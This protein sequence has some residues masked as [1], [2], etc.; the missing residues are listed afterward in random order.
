MYRKT[1]NA[2]TRG[3]E[4]KNEICGNLLGWIIIEIYK[5][6]IVGRYVHINEYPYTSTFLYYGWCQYKGIFIYTYIAT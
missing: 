5:F 2:L 3:G 6:K 4:F 1:R